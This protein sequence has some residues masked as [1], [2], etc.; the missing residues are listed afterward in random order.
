M[1]PAFAAV[2]ACI[3]ALLEA[4]T[5]SRYEIF[6]A[7]LQITLVFAVAVTL[8]YGFESGMT[9]AFLG[10]LC[11]DLFMLRP[12]GS[13]IF[14]LLIVVALTTIA[15]PL[16]GRSRYL[17]C[18]IATVV[19]VPL[20]LVI[21]DVA[22]GMLQP[23][24]PPLSATSLIASAIANGLIALVAS[25]LVIGMKRRAEHRERVLWWR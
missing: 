13:T 19:T 5:A 24:A 8:V 12:L 23:P 4:T 6:G 15:Q 2:G 17:G 16:L 7:Q 14:E 3:A 22:T 11:L 25:P 9:W 10:G 1:G 21:S 20:F 18:V